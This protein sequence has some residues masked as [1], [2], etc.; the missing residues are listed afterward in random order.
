[1]SQ[2]SEQPVSIIPVPDELKGVVDDDRIFPPYGFHDAQ[3]I[4]DFMN[5]GG[6]AVYHYQNDDGFWTELTFYIGNNG[7]GATL[8]YI[9]WNMTPVGASVTGAVILASSVAYGGYHLYKMATDVSWPDDFVDKVITVPQVIE[10]GVLR[11]QSGVYGA[12]VFQPAEHL[13]SNFTS[14]YRGFLDE[15]RVAISHHNLP[16][17]TALYEYGGPFS[18]GHR[19][20]YQSVIMNSEWMYVDPVN[21]YIG[22]VNWGEDEVDS[23]DLSDDWYVSTELMEAIHQYVP[24]KYSDFVFAPSNYVPETPLFFNQVITA[25]SQMTKATQFEYE[26][27]YKGDGD[28]L[29]LLNEPPFSPENISRFKDLLRSH[30]IVTIDNDEKLWNFFGMEM[31]GNYIVENYI[32]LK[33]DSEFSRELLRIGSI[34]NAGYP[35]KLSYEKASMVWQKTGNNS[36][37]W[38]SLVWEPY[39]QE[40]YMKAWDKLYRL[41][42]DILDANE[43]A[44]NEVV[45]GRHE[46]FW[47][48][49]ATL[50]IND[51]RFTRKDDQGNYEEELKYPAGQGY[52]G[53]LGAIGYDDRYRDLVTGEWNF[54]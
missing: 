3:F 20:N 33:E 8:L 38:Q 44:R 2:T 48:D 46:M 1:M 29:P 49:M 18:E 37:M 17:S 39:S 45:T 11:S 30:G 28:D 34:L 50:T 9:T 24:E 10:P 16:N 21:G 42:F 35:I 27:S 53:K 5:N 25:H 47:G 22:Y 43:V 26:L 6:K 14:E 32:R 31:P 19:G 4:Q 52:K 51:M 12:Q 40:G 23:G 13:L 15:W 7:T 41:T 36:G 54:D